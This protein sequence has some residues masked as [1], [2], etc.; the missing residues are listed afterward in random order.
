MNK[1]LTDEEIYAMT[2]EQQR[3]LYE[4]LEKQLQELGL[5]TRSLAIHRYLE[6]CLENHA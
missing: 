4:Q 1:G 2:P 3:E 6:S 5:S